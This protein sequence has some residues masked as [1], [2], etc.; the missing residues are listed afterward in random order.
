MKS[1][2]FVAA[3]LAGPV[4]HAAEPAVSYQGVAA[5]PATAAEKEIAGLFDKWNAA[6]A[7]GKTSE[8]V[9]LY[10]ANGILQPTVSNRIRATPAE[11]GDYFDHFLALKPKGTI[12]YRQIRVLDENTALDSGAYTFDIVKDGKPAKV[13]A[14]Y[15]YVYEKINGEWKI[16]NHH[17]SAMPEVAKEN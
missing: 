13:R 17:S 4:V 3:L 12:N 2:L 16:M 11:I 15:T 5:V 7:T 9:K 8:V 14:R 1:M 6:L 10:A